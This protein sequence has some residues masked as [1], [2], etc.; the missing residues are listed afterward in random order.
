[1][2]SQP[3][4]AQHAALSH[5]HESFLLDV[6]GSGIEREFHWRHDNG[7]RPEHIMM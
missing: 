7:G 1:M 6:S 2:P 5:P 3:Y 4:L